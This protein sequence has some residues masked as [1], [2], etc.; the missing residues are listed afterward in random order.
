[1][2]SMLSTASTYLRFLETLYLK[3][4]ICVKSSLLAV[5]ASK[6]HF[7]NVTRLRYVAF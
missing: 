6:A 1:M 4:C 7:S 2:L 5:G 3:M